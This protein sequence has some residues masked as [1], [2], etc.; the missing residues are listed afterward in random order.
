MKAKSPMTPAP[1]VP[2]IIFIK[3]R[4]KQ[5]SVGATGSK[6][7]QRGHRGCGARVIKNLQLSLFLLSL[8]ATIIAGS[9]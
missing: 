2:Y 5:L 9:E 6:G 3:L 1:S 8:L 7:G 4:D